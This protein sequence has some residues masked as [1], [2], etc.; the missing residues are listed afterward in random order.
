MPDLSSRSFSLVSSKERAWG[1]MTFASS[2]TR[3]V[4]AGNLTAMAAK[5]ASTI[6]ATSATLTK[7]K[8]N[9]ITNLCSLPS[10][11]HFGRSLRARSRCKLLHG[12][13]RSEHG[14]RPQHTRNSPERGI[15]IASRLDV[16]SAR[17][18]DAI[19]RTLEL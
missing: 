18:G 13:I 5:L 8:V 17:D 14:H 3:P 4:S 19:L 6:A 9:R 16:V 2:T 11:L 10:E 15:V 12:F 1:A 7:P